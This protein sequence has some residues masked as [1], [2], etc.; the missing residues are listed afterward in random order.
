MALRSFGPPSRV[1]VDYQLR[2][3]GMPLQYAVGVNCAMDETPENQGI[4]AWYM[5]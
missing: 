1:L 2:R 5:G 4:G 3:S